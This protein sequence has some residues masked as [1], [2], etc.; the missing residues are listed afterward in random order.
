[1]KA[2]TAPL[3]A[4][5]KA[6]ESRELP[7]DVLTTKELD[8]ELDRKLREKFEED[9]PDLVTQTLLQQLATPKRAAGGGKS[10]PAQL[11]GPCPRQPH[12]GKCPSAWCIKAQ[13]AQA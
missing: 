5:I 1:M 6:L 12:N 11:T 7:D 2:A 4:R 13:A 3:E 8:R 10:E 9:L